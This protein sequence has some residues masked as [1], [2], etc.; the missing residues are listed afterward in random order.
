MYFHHIRSY[1]DLCDVSNDVNKDVDASEEDGLVEE[2]VVV[3]EEN[4]GVVHWG[5]PNG[6]DTNLG[7]I[8]I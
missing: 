4:R 1:S 5:E 2:L 6:G 7:I 8:Q 3:V